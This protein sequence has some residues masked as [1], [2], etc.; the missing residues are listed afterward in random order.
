MPISGLHI[1]SSMFYGLTQ[2]TVPVHSCLSHWKIC[3]DLYHC[4]IL[5]RR[6]NLFQ[7]LYLCLLVAFRLAG[8]RYIN[9]LW[10]ILNL[11]LCR[12]TIALGS[13]WVRI[14]LSL[15]WLLLKEKI[16]YDTDLVHSARTLF[17]EGTWCLTNHFNNKPLCAISFCRVCRCF[18]HHYSLSHERFMRP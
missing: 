9:S 14:L 1:L 5:L 12:H 15:C 7:N 4:L 17:V 13:I 18:I 11:N 2:S 8:S 16:I 3:F 10:H 6:Q